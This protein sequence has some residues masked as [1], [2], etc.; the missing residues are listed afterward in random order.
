MWR[1]KDPRC[2]NCEK[3]RKNWGIIAFGMSGIF[4]TP[5]PRVIEVIATY[6]ALTDRAFD[7]ALHFSELTAAMP[8]LMVYGSL[9]DEAVQD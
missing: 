2:R 9:S 8:G 3:A 6:K 4:N 1:L 5:S 7:S